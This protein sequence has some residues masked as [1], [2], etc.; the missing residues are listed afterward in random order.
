MRPPDQPR[1]K[2]AAAASGSI[3]ANNYLKLKSRPAES[4]LLKAESRKQKAAPLKRNWPTASHPGLPAP[5]SVFA[6][7]PQ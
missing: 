6:P 2:T 7:V 3:A 4:W 1:P 5:P